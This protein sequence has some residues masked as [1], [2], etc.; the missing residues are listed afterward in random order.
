VRGSELAGYGYRTKQC[1]AALL[2]MTEKRMQLKWKLDIV[3]AEYDRYIKTQELDASLLGNPFNYNR[4]NEDE[5]AFVWGLTLNGVGGGD[6]S[7]EGYEF[8]AAEYT[9]INKRTKK[10]NAHSM[11][12]NGKPVFDTKRKTLD[13]LAD[14][15]SHIKGIKIAIRTPI[16]KYLHFESKMNAATRQI[17]LAHGEEKYEALQE[18]RKDPRM[19]TK[20]TTS[21]LLAINNLKLLKGTNEAFARRFLGDTYNEVV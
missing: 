5:Q 14:Y 19:N 9:G 17:L 2:K 18:G 1:G 3:C 20:I 7:K 6:D 16:G 12:F 11:S 21:E 4:L 13:Y 8:K 15:L 10:L